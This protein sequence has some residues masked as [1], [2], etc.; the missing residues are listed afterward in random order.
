[1][2]EQDSADV[3]RFLDRLDARSDELAEESA[4]RRSR[5]AVLTWEYLFFVIGTDDHGKR[6]I[7]SSLQRYQQEDVQGDFAEIINTLGAEGWEM[8]NCGMG[9]PDRRF[10]PYLHMEAVFKRPKLEG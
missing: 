5:A 9:S 10:F 6:F 1:M 3:D 2:S 8:I 7:Q 4:S